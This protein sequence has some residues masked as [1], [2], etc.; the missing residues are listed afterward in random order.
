M[1]A[2]ASASVIRHI[3]PPFCT[4]PDRN[5]VRNELGAIHL[6]GTIRRSPRK[7]F[8][9][10]STLRPIAEGPPSIEGRHRYHEFNLCTVHK[11]KLATAAGITVITIASVAHH[12][13]NADNL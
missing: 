2:T 12:H 5:K 13:D 6:N 7:I 11:L 3:A 8:L 10:H 4:V 9:L 1:K